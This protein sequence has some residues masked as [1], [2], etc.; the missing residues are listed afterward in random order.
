MFGIGLLVVVMWDW[1]LEKLQRKLHTWK[2]KD[3]HVVILIHTCKRGLSLNPLRVS[4]EAQCLSPSPLPP[5]I[6]L[7]SSRI[8]PREAKGG[9]P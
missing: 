8:T 6:E 9:R 1:C 3:L 7:L 4:L 2:F 5:R